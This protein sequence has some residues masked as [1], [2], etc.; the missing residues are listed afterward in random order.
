MLHHSHTSI[1][2]GLRLMIPALMG[3]LSGCDHKDLL[4]D[5]PAIL[6][7]LITVSYDWVKTPYTL[8]NGMANIFYPVGHD[9]GSYWRSDFRPEGGMVRMPGGEYIAV[10]FNND[11]EIVR[12]SGIDAISGF[13]FHTPPVDTGNLA[14][15]QLPF[16]PQR[17][18]RQPDRMWSDTLRDINILSTS[19]RDSVSFH[20]RVITR[21]YHIEMT[22][23]V[24]LQSALRYYAVISD[25]S[26]SYSPELQQPAGD[27]VC[28]GGFMSPM[29]SSTI[30]STVTSFGMSPRS[31]KCRLAVYMWLADGAKKMYQYDV[32]DQIKEAPDSM[33]LVIRVKGPELPYIKPDQGDGGGGLDIG[34]DDW[35]FVEIEL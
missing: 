3:I 29:D 28:M 5:E 26:A 20:P 34:I 4:I 25:L 11:T 6:N 15:D 8:P 33:N 9:P 30:I 31:Q 2:R 19:D 27:A 17:L 18:Y 24:N 23:I 13:I 12:F 1:F 21:D 32:T 14:A 35:E 7:P 10:T 22:D 16:P